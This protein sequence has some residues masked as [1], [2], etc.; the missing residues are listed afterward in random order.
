MQSVADAIKVAH[1]HL[2]IL[3]ANAGGSHATP[4]AATSAVSTWSSMAA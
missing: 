3:F 1:G 4:L 2:D